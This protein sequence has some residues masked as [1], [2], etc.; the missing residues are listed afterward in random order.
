MLRYDTATIA[1]ELPAWLAFGPYGSGVAD[2]LEAIAAVEPSAI[3]S[4]DVP[5]DL[6]KWRI[7]V[8]G[9]AWDDR[10][11]LAQMARRAYFSAQQWMECRGWA[12]DPRAGDHYYRGCY[13]DYNLHEPHWLSAM[14]RA[15]NAAALAAL[16][17]DVDPRE[18]DRVRAEW[19]E[20]VG[21]PRRRDGGAVVAEP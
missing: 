16:G 10:H 6:P 15:S 4:L 1:A 14:G 8:D 20:V 12:T 17:G 5:E 19:L 3:W 9:L 2:V 11:P 18:R 21:A 7:A 13:F